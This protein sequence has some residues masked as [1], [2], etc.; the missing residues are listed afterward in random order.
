M[1]RHFPLDADL[2]LAALQGGN[3]IAL[4][5]G[6]KISR[7]FSVPFSGALFVPLNQD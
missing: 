7:P 5:K 2:L 3:S 4:K 1:S 6:P